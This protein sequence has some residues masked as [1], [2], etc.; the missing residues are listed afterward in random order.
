M[1]AQHP[2]LLEADG[3]RRLPLKAPAPHEPP[4]PPFVDSVLVV[5]GL[6]A[7]GHSLDPEWVYQPDR[8]AALAGLAPGAPITPEGLVQV[9]RHPQGGLKNIP[10]GARRLAVVLVVVRSA[11]GQTQTE[12]E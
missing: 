8:F 10:A 9:L 6:S 3:S 5:A 2:F 12:D 11:G 7:L 4:I 1:T